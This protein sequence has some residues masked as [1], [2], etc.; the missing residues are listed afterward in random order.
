MVRPLI[1]AFVGLLATLPRSA[2]QE[3]ARTPYTERGDREFNFYPGG[4]ITIAANVAGNVKVIGWKRASVRVEWEKILYGVPPEE[5]R[6]VSEQFPVSV[7]HNQTSVTVRMPGPPQPTPTVEINAALWVPALR[8]DLAITMSKG[9]LAVGGINGWIEATLQEG[10]VEAKSVTGYVSLQTRLG[11]LA[12]ELAGK[13]FDGHSFTA[14]TQNGAA[15][16]RLPEGYSAALDLVTDGALQIDYPEQLVEGERVPLRA[17][18]RKNTRSLKATVGDGGA[19]IRIST[20]GGD[21]R[22][23]T[24]QTP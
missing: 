7:R 3:P 24:T 6:A 19:P 21:I 22:L 20:I 8:T 2:G 10:N 9:D 4:K 15:T 11:N 14:A 16:L 5:T 12:F 17:V 23:S 18:V 1:L 13:R